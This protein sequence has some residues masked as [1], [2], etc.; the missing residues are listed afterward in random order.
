MNPAG[1]PAVRELAKEYPLPHEDELI[2]DLLAMRE[3][4]VQRGPADVFVRESH[5]KHHGCVRA[6]FVVEPDLPAELR[7]GVFAQQPAYSAWIRFSNASPLARNGT[8]RADGRPDVRGMAIKLEGVEGE[9]LL[10]DEGEETAQ[11]FLLVSA[12]ALVA[13]D[14]ADFVRALG[15]FRIGRLLWYFLNPFRPRLRELGVGIRSPRRHAS[16][17]EVEYFTVVPFLLGDRA[18]KYKARPVLERRTETPRRARAD[19]LRDAMR[20]RLASGEARFELLVQVQT[21][22]YTMPIE[23]PSVVWRSP[24]RKVATI[25]IP[26]QRFDTAERMRECEGLSFNPWHSIPEHRPLGG[27]NRA[28]KVVYPALSKLRHDRNAG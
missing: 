25:E 15:E 24:F 8:F 19:F 5:P 26:A 10:E 6:R 28:R 11:D 3:K 21:D 20:E 7:V 2:R 13:R 4:R 27:I 16:P 14:L 22:P 1:E 9:K 18:V 23:D 17:L 12:D